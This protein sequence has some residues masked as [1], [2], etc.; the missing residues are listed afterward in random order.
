MSDTTSV[1]QPTL[2]PVGYIAPTAPAIL[3]GV[4]TDWTSA[5]GSG[6]NT[7]LETPQGQVMSSEAAI[8]A[9]KDT[10]FLYLTSM[11]DPAYSRGRW[12]DALGRYYFIVREPAVATAPSCLCIGA[13]GVVIPQGTPVTAEDSNTYTATST[14]TI[15]SGG[16]L[17]L[18]FGCTV[19]GP[20]ACPAQTFQISQVIPGW[21]QCYST[22]SAVEGQNVESRQAFEYRRA[23]SVEGNSVNTNAAVLGAL[24]SIPGIESAYV[25]DN[26][27]TSTATIGGVTLNANSIFCCISGAA[28]TL[29]NG[30]FEGASGTLA[31]AGTIFTKKP[32]GCGYTGATSVTVQDPNPAYNG[33]GPSYS[34]SYTVASALPINM[35]VSIPNTTAVPNNA[36]GLITLAYLSAFAGTDGNSPVSQIG[37]E[38]FASRFYAGIA[39]LGTWASNIAALNIGT[40]TAT[41]LTVA[42][43]I[44]QIPV[45]GTVALTLV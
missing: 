21:D 35:A 12:Q 41:S 17:T 27:A 13:A 3:T 34:V 4:Q 16:T 37:K 26:S 22:A 2:G 19:T 5:F 23:L 40:S 15:P 45:A 9:D 25:V 20:I 29:T 8:I 44:A 28:G 43:T 39:A 38:V 11:M 24:L 10:Q 33:S 6:L 32:P 31:I 14:G 18:S 36:A 1:P 7:S 30:P 42:C